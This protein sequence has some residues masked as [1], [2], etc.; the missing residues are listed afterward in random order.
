MSEWQNIETA[1]KDGTVIE[2]KRT[3]EGLEFQGLGSWRTVTFSSFINGTHGIEPEQT[4]T[5]WMRVSEE[6]RFPEPTHWR[7]QS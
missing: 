3:H 6:K 7:P 2:L 4:V 1:P 5:G